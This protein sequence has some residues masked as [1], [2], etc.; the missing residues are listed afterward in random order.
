MTYFFSQ[1]MPGNTGHISDT[2][3]VTSTH[4]RGQGRLEMPLVK[5]SQKRYAIFLDPNSEGIGDNGL[6][7]GKEPDDKLVL[8]LSILSV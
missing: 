4:R 2:S 5:Q 6:L 7:F 1:L 8:Y 3:S